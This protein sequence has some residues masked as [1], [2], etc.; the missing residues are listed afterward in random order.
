MAADPEATEVGQG[1]DGDRQADREAD[2]AVADGEVY[3]V[4]AGGVVEE[5]AHDAEEG[6]GEEGGEAGGEAHEQRGEP[7]KIAD[8]NTEE[9][10]GT[11][12]SRLQGTAALLLT[13][14]ACALGR[15]A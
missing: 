5:D 14:A 12:G 2:P 15:S 3:R 4:V 10:A 11:E 13:G 1:E 6:C 8:G 9:E 7:A